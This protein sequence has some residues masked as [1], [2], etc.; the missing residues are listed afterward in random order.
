MTNPVA[1]TSVVISGAE[2]TAGSTLRRWARIGTHAATVVD[3]TQIE[4][5]VTA[6]VSASLNGAFQSS[7]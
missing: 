6:T 7:A 2:S 5:I 3:Q 4:N 1:S